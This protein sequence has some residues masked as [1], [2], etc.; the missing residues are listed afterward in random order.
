MPAVS[1]K[2]PRQLAKRDMVRFPRRDAD[3]GP[4]TSHLRPTCGTAGDHGSSRAGMPFL[5]SSVS[6]GTSWKP[7]TLVFRLHRSGRPAARSE[8]NTSELQ[9]LMSIYSAIL[10]LNKTHTNIH[11]PH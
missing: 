1:R 2:T 3:R 7:R 11:Q 8:E 6:G 5:C 4:R 9:S 10:Y